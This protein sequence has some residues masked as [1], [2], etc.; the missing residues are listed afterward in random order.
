MTQCPQQPSPLQ[1]STAMCEE[2]RG[3]ETKVHKEQRNYR[4]LKTAAP[5]QLLMLGEDFFSFLVG[6]LGNFHQ[7]AG[8]FGDPAE[9]QLQ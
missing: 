5:L 8:L 1:S 4:T 9:I 6:G 7:I 2:M 3:A